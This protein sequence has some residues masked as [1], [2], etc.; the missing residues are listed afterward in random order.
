MSV[1]LNFSH[2]VITI[3]MRYLYSVPYNIGRIH[4]SFF[5]SKIHYYW[6]TK[7]A[8]IILLAGVFRRLSCVTL[9]AVCGRSDGRHC[10]A[11]QYSYVPLRRHFV[12][13]C[14]I[15]RQ[16]YIGTT[17]ATSYNKVLQTPTNYIAGYCLCLDLM[18]KKYAL[19][20]ICNMELVP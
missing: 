16:K 1:T 13:K 2:N 11:G 10:M 7:W 19:S 20:L 14:T 5:L 8:S 17:C 15:H 3:T 6:P 12:K 18:L 9:L 4:L